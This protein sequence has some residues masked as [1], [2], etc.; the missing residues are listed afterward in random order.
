MWFT[1]SYDFSQK[2]GETWRTY[3]NNK[4]GRHNGKPIG[5]GP[6]GPEALFQASDI[7]EVVD[8][9]TEQLATVPTLHLHPAPNG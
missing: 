9:L 3:A 5:Y 2:V 6:N 8:V 1:I 7:V 4:V